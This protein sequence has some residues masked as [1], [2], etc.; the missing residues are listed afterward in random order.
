MDAA[1][2]KFLE[3][4]VEA[5]VAYQ[6]RKKENP[7]GYEDEIY[8]HPA[9]Y[10]SKMQGMATRAEDLL[11]ENQEDGFL[12]VCRVHRNDIRGLGIDDTLISDEY[13]QLIANKLDDSLVDEDWWMKLEYAA[14]ECGFISVAK[15]L[16]NL[17]EALS[18]ETKSEPQIVSLD[19]FIQA[20]E[21]AAHPAGLGLPSD[22]DLADMLV[23]TRDL[24]LCQS[25]IAGILEW[26]TFQGEHEMAAAV[27]RART[28][29]QEQSESLL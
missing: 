15:R 16:R 2:R 26:L 3:E 4:V 17:Y 19:L 20:F 14:E 13:F 5:A 23:D 8:E 6:P 25:T 1:T 11:R 21:D 10:Y 9:D 24:D 22:E 12:V 7:G 28:L 18:A 29:Q 27:L